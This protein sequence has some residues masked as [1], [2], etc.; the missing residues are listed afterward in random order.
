MR[1]FITGIGGLLGTHLTARLLSQGWQITALVRNEVSEEKARQNLS[2]Y[3]GLSE[4]QIASII[5]VHG[6]L[7]Q[8]WL[9]ENHLADIGALV[10]CAGMVS[11]HPSDRKELYRNNVLGTASI[12]D[13]A[14]EAAV[15]YFVHISSVAT[16]CSVRGN[17]L[18][19]EKPLD[20]PTGKKSVYANSKYLA[21]REVWRGIEEGLQAVIL[22]P[23]VILGYHD[24]NKGSSA[25]FRTAASGL[26]F[27]TQG[28]TGFVPVEDVSE[29]ILACIEKKIT[30]ER[31]IISAGNFSFREIFSKM[32]KGF[33]NKEPSIYAGPRISKMYVLLSGIW[34]LLAGKKP[35]VTGESARSAHAIRQFD[36]S[37]SVRLLN[38]SYGDTMRLLID[39]SEKYKKMAKV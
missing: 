36:N 25:M 32:S 5:F 22:N 14:L 18:I 35:L 6:S 7:E 19:S 1:V 39:L 16:L 2:Y 28:V 17:P 8:T 13:A 37:K 26:R 9:Y 30:S 12:V 27:Y 15:P 23:S 38:I 3:G 10:H 31:I 29:A 33:D 20:A 11:F 34:G 24:W 4:T 21:E